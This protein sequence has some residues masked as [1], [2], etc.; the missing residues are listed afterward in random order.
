LE[1]IGFEGVKKG[2]NKEQKPQEFWT[3]VKLGMLGFVSL[4]NWWLKAR[5]YVQGFRVLIG[6]RIEFDLR[7]QKMRR[8]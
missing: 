3:V 6:L 2:W 1:K 7:L 5:K 8:S 4:V